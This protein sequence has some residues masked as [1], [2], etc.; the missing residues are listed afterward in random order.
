MPEEL[1]T[2]IPIVI[3]IFTMYGIYIGFL[4]YI[5]Q[6]NEKYLNKVK[7]LYLLN[8]H[9]RYKITKGRFLISMFI[10]LLI[11]PFIYYL[12]KDIPLI[13]NIAC[14]II[15]IWWAVVI[16]LCLL[17]IFLLSLSIKITNYAYSR[18]KNINQQLQCEIEENI[19]KRYSELFNNIKNFDP[20]NFSENFFRNVQYDIKNIEPSDIKSY[21]KIIFY[22][23]LEHYEQ[24]NLIAEANTNYCF[25]ISEKLKFILDFDKSFLYDFISYDCDL[26]DQFSEFRKD[27]TF[28]KNYLETIFNFKDKIEKNDIEKIFKHPLFK[29]KVLYSSVLLKV[30]TSEFISIQI[31]NSKIEILYNNMEIED[32][33]CFILYQ[34]FSTDIKNDVNH[35]GYTNIVFFKKELKSIFDDLS[36]IDEKINLFINCSEL[37]ENNT[38]IGHKITKSDLKKIFEDGDK[39]IINLKEIYKN[40][41]EFEKY[42]FKFLIIQYIIYNKRA[43][44]RL[45]KNST[46]ECNELIEWC[47][48]Y[49][50]IYKNF[51]EFIESEDNL[52]SFMKKIFNILGINLNRL[53]FDLS[54]QELLFLYNNFIHDSDIF[55]DY[56]KNALYREEVIM[57]ICIK[58]NIFCE[59]LNKN[60]LKEKIEYTLNRED[61]NIETFTDKI[62]DLLI[63]YNTI[64]ISKYEAFKINNFL[65]K[66][67][68]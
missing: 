53:F 36:N 38:N 55:V 21:L 30:L 2:S 27:T 32:K 49:L 20:K 50:K 68:K 40:F 24:K 26:L 44:D 14:I 48:D 65:N 63:D 23:T 37:I 57:F 56:I 33:V 67:L 7:I 34:M 18:N 19:Q 1:S 13:K 59:K 10:I 15:F 5:S 9:K 66:I 42:K 45:S 43:K 51:P 8:M 46:T 61:M 62:Y 25:F 58:S 3:A 35:S 6:Y 41:S 47:K 52:Y 17:F 60:E 12:I 16:F 39:H 28:F 29:N 31:E 54:L 22:T 64:K 4:Q 11:L